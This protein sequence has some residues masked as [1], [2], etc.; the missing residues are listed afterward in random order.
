MGECP[1]ASFAKGAD[2]G[3]NL[4]TMIG[5]FPPE[6]QKSYLGETYTFVNPMLKKAR[7]KFPEQEPAYE[8]IKYVMTNQSL[9]YEAMLSDKNKVVRQPA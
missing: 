4:M 3:H 1:I 2:R 6:K 7:R 8:N 5:G 9:L